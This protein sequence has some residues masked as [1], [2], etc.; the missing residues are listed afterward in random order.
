M[1]IFQN[2]DFPKV[3]FPYSEFSET[4]FLDSGHPKFDFPNFIFRILDVPKK[5]FP[6]VGFPY[7]EL[8]ET[9]FPGIGHAKF[10]FSN[11]I[12]QDHELYQILFSEYGRSKKRLRLFIGI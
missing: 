4:R 3:G 9:W 7:S 11:F 12:F 2:S 5:D 1:L 8:S 6:K 10:D